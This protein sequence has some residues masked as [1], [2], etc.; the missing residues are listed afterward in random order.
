MLRAKPHHVLNIAF[1]VCLA[2]VA[3][4]HVP[5]VKNDSVLHA[6]HVSIVKS[7]GLALADFFEELPASPPLPAVAELLRQ[8]PACGEASFIEKLAV[9]LG[10]ARVVHAQNTCIA[11]PCT[12]RYVRLVQGPCGGPCFGTYNAGFTNGPE[13]VGFTQ[14]RYTVCWGGNDNVGG[15]CPCQKYECSTAP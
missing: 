5:K 11:V 13:N 9:K 14:M 7:G 3:F 8:L 12:G 2:D 1:L 15:G 4:Q 10:I 6:P